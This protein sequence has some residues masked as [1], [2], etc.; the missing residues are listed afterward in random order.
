MVLGADVANLSDFDLDYRFGAAGESLVHELLTGGKTVE[1]KRDRKWHVTGNLYIEI[2]CWYQ[3]TES[4]KDSGITTSLADYWAFVLNS[5]V[6]MVQVDVLV[7]AV[8]K[9]GKRIECNIEPNR[10]RGYLL[11]VDHLLQV[12]K[13]SN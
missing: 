7:K 2:M 11:S 5:S 8:A 4:W 1:V 13:E 3:G 9:Y 12:I 6:L 10:S